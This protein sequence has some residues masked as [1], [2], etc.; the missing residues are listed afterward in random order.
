MRSVFT[1]ANHTESLSINRPVVW[2]CAQGHCEL[3]RCQLKKSVEGWYPTKPCKKK[4]N[5]MSSTI[6]HLVPMNI[7]TRY[8]N[9]HDKCA[10]YNLYFFLVS[11]KDLTVLDNTMCTPVKVFLKCLSPT[12]YSKH[13]HRKNLNKIKHYHSKQYNNNKHFGTKA[14]TFK[15]LKWMYFLYE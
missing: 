1:E 8:F 12:S 4:K 6:I 13:C 14:C 15:L 7:Q 9:Y 2:H 10:K 11:S 3:D 5:L